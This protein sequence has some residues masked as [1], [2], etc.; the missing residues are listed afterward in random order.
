MDS[1]F[2][3]FF[4]SS[5]YYESQI[6]RASI[7]SRAALKSHLI[8]CVCVAIG[9]GAGQRRIEDGGRRMIREKLLVSL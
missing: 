7:S 8:L 4:L 1:V 9:S 2:N 3:T 6:S 5:K